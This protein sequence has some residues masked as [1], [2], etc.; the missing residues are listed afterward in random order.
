MKYGQEYD[1]KVAEGHDMREYEN[2]ATAH[3][4]R[5]KYIKDDLVGGLEAYR[6]ISYKSLA[7]HIGNWCSKLPSRSG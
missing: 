6:C 1:T 7:Q 2:P 5:W 3:D 4:A